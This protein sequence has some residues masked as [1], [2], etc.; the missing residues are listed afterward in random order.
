MT[1]AVGFH[2]A[3]LIR[4]IGIDMIPKSIKIP[5][6]DVASNVLLVI[7]VVDSQPVFTALIV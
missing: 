3:P 2:A 5:N 6:N 7:T 1:F 4:S